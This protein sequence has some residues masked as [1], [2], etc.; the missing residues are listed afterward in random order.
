M[1][2]HSNRQLIVQHV[3][4][5][6]DSYSTVNVIRHSAT[7][8]TQKLPSLFFFLYRSRFFSLTFIVSTLCKKAPDPSIHMHIN[9]RLYH[10][11][12][13][14]QTL[15]MAQNDIAVMRVT[16]VRNFPAKL[17]IHFVKSFITKLQHLI[18]H[19]LPKCPPDKRHTS[20][21]T[22]TFKKYKL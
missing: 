12:T 2:R 7:C 17:L 6:S 21:Q 16:T 10:K 5:Q 22:P 13:F 8:P 14:V 15:L 3:I 4:G 1:G 18:V 19:L 9:T 20:L 11:W